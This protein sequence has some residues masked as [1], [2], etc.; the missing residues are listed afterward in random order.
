MPS[1][2]RSR[3]LPAVALPAL[4]TALAAIA[5]ASALEGVDIHGTIEGIQEQSAR[6]VGRALVVSGVLSGEGRLDAVEDGWRASGDMVDVAFLVLAHKLG[7]DPERLR[8]LMPRRS[9]ISRNKRL[10]AT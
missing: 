7:E 1:K 10:S 6:D 9:Q 8:S 2:P 4:A 3:G 5:G